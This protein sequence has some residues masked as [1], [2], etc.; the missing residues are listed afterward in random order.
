MGHRKVANVCDSKKRNLFALWEFAHLDRDFVAQ[1]VYVDGE[2][3]NNEF[4]LSAEMLRIRE[5]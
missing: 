5:V 4:H 1:N 3:R 2:P